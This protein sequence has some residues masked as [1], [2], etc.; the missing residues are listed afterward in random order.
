[1]GK[2]IKVE[3]LMENWKNNRNLKTKKKGNKSNKKQK[4]CGTK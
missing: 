4:N 1:M 3:S 2:E